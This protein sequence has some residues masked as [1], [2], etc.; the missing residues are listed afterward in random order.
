MIKPQLSQFFI[1]NPIVFTDK[2]YCAVKNTTMTLAEYD[3][4]KGVAGMDPD[5][6]DDDRS[7]CQMVRN[8]NGLTDF[9]FHPQMVYVV[10]LANNAVMKLGTYSGNKGN[11]WGGSKTRSLFTEDKRLLGKSYL[12]DP[13]HSI[14]VLL[15]KIYSE[16]EDQNV[17]DYIIEISY[18]FERINSKILTYEKINNL[19]ENE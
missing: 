6:I 13:H 7:I 19:Q 3:K 11:T 9:K 12:D 2:L 15:N 10:N 5:K 8:A 1:D 4:S 17:K 18:Y 14:Y 16:I